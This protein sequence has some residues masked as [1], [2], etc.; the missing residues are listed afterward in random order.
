MIE[1]SKFTGIENTDMLTLE[2]CV[3]AICMTK[4]IILMAEVLYVKLTQERVAEHLKTQSLAQ[5]CFK[6]RMLFLGD[7]KY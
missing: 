6:G 4:I 7:S 5:K 3:K 1:N 2:K